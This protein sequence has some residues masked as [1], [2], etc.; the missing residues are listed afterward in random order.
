MIIII[1]IVIRIII[2]VVVV[3]MG[4]HGPDGVGRGRGVLVVRGYNIRLL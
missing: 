2:V 3:D 1:I 4:H